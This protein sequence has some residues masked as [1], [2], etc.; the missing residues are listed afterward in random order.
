MLD[1][2]IVVVELGLVANAKKVALA[3]ARVSLMKDFDF[4]CERQKNYLSNLL[5]FPC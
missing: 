3:K 2:S 5:R 1:N 4:I